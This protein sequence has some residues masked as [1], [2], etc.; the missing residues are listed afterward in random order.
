MFSISAYA[1]K[2]ERKVRLKE[3]TAVLLKRDFQCSCTRTMPIRYSYVE[4]TRE[5]EN[6]KK[7]GFNHDLEIYLGLLSGVWGA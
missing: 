1:T 6:R 5:R 7:R 2:H 3:K 4:K